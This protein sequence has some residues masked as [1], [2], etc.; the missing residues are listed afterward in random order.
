M[1]ILPLDLIYS[2]GKLRL[3]TVYFPNLNDIMGS[4]W[5]YNDLNM[6]IKKCTNFAIIGDINAPKVD[7]KNSLFPSHNRYKYLEKFFTKSANDTINYF[8]YA[9]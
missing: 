2:K 7:W 6:L 9:R 3:I 5:F 1:E 8:T 4:K